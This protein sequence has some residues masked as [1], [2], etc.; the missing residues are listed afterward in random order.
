MEKKIIALLIAVI[1]VASAGIAMGAGK[2][3]PVPF[4]AT[5]NSTVT[6][7]GTITPTDE[8]LLKVRNQIWTGTVTN[9]SITGLPGGNIILK[10]DAMIDLS[11]GTG[12]YH[13]AFTITTTGGTV[14]GKL[15][16]KITNLTG[17]YPFFT[18]GESDGSVTI[19]GGTGNWQ[20]IQGTG[21][22]H[23]EYVAPLTTTATMTGQY[24]K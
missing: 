21:T 20:G 12:T 6:D 24:H 2:G 19:Q 9:T 22:Y 11:R 3:K 18:G 4:T 23:E 16:G 7:P 15:R 10:H 13:A 5:V 14:Y 1:L 17:T 8:G